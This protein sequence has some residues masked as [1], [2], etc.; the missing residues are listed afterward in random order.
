MLFRKK[1][2]RFAL[3]AYCDSA[4]RFGSD[5]ETYEGIEATGGALALHDLKLSGAREAGDKV[6][7]RIESAGERAWWLFSF[8]DGLIVRIE[9]HRQRDKAIRALYA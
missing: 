9:A 5:A 8:S 2:D 7:A 4:V 1:L 6:L 3:H